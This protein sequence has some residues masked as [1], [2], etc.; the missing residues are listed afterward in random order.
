MT[1]FPFFRERSL[2]PAESEMQF[3]AYL[4]KKLVEMDSSASPTS[5]SPSSSL[6][7]PPN[8]PTV[9]KHKREI[10]SGE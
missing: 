10:P 4:Q 7:T 5:L 8:S 3:K 1:F 9:S 6:S 2:T